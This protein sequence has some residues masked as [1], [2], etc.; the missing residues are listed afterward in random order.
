MN[1]FVVDK[2]PV[3]S[4]QMLPDKILN[5]MAL[6]GMQMLATNFGPKFFNWGSIP[7]KD[8]SPCGT[9]GFPNHPCTIWLREK[10]ENLA[11]GITHFLALAKEHRFRYN[12]LPSS[13]KSIKVAQKLFE[14]KTG[15]TLEVWGLLEEN[16]FTR[17]MPLEIKSNS[18][19]S[20]VEAYR[21]YM[22][23]KS[24]IHNYNKKPERKPKWVI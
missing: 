1:L 12:K 6:E 22:N 3:V 10:H 14:K 18:S 2:N 24:Y 4:A 7:K 21:M 9:N 20:D 11:W 16:D 5:K 19:L 8:G 17:A 13:F 15:L 23:T